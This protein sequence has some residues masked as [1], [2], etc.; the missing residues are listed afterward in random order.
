[1]GKA[2]L[3][4]VF[5]D[6]HASTAQSLNKLDY[7]VA[8]ILFLSMFGVSFA[9]CIP[10]V[11]GTFH[12][13]AVYITISKSLAEGHGYR[14][15]SF[16]GDPAQMKYP[17]LYPLIL[18]TVW[19]AL[20]KFPQNL[21]ALQL[22]S[23][24]SA[25]LFLPLSYL[26]LV[27]FSYASRVVAA[28]AAAICVSIPGF[29]FF[30]GQVLSEMPFALSLI[31]CLWAMDSYCTNRYQSP[32]VQ[33]LVGV[34]VAAPASIRLI[35]WVA[36]IASL[37]VL[38]RR[39]LLNP[40]LI[41]SC[42]LTALASVS[43]V[44]LGIGSRTGGAS[45]RIQ[46]YQDNYIEW[47]LRLAISHEFAV[48]CKNLQEMLAVTTKAL[49]C[50]VSQT[51]N[52][53]PYNL[54][55]YVFGGLL[56]WGVV[57]GGV[58][59]MKPLATL[60]AGY[61]IVVILWPWPPFRFLIPLMP[62]LSAGF[63]GAVS[64]LLAR[65]KMRSLIIVLLAVAMAATN[66]VFLTAVVRNNHSNQMP[67]ISVPRNGADWSGFEKLFDWIKHNTADDDTLACTYDGLTFLYTGRKCIRPYD[68]NIGAAYYGQSESMLGTVEE[69]VETLKRYKVR[70]LVVTP[71][72]GYAE[73][74]QAY[75]LASS[76]GINYKESVEP[77]YISSDGRFVVLRITFD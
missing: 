30:G 61:A 26:Y 15:V 67:L 39:R 31:V 45:D 47:A 69:L 48:V 66:A 24:F 50:G 42:S 46:S 57:V 56:A 22:V 73:E 55:L 63:L 49:F 62:F 53:T 17:I 9:F 52:P 33:F 65:V 54:V 4:V 16:P 64:N 6:E 75:S 70:F 5:N 10:E 1:M 14:I 76:L 35:G 8:A 28:S 71:Q 51:V 20:P 27:R 11:A 43:H 23:V 77:V 18:A 34:A 3:N 68:L 7:V 38:W 12:D 58:R 21:F 29:A 2:L 25:S 44:L 40:I 41:V 19:T 74:G 36:P 37:V 72:P 59:Q 32:I 60:V 13:D